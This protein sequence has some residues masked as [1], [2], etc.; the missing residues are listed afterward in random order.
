MAKRRNSRRPHEARR[1]AT[2]NKTDKE[3]FEAYKFNLPKRYTSE[4]AYGLLKISRTTFF[5]RLHSGAIPFIKD[6]KKV[7]ILE[8][9]LVKYMKEGFAE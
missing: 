7:F 6:G 4:E 5:K 1:V 9:D 8:Q 3:A 2:M